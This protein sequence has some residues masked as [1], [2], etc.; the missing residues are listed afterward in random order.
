MQTAASFPKN[1][2]CRNVGL[3]L[4]AFAAGWMLKPAAS[5]HTAGTLPTVKAASP[6]SMDAPPVHSILALGQR[7]TDEAFAFLQ[8]LSA[9]DELAV[10]FGKLWLSRW[11][12]RESAQAAWAAALSLP[13]GAWRDAVMERL[14]PDLE[15]SVP[16]YAWRES[17]RLSTEAAF[18]AREGMVQ[19]QLEGGASPAD[20]ASLLADTPAEEKEAAASIMLAALTRQS[21]ENAAALLQTLTDPA[22]KEAA[23]VG[24]TA[25]WAATAPEAAA[26]WCLNNATEAG[27][28]IS[29]V[30]QTWCLAD[31]PA[32]SAWLAKLPAGPIRDQGAYSLIES[33][34][35]TNPDLA[36]KWTEQLSDPAAR[37]TFQDRLNLADFTAADP[38]S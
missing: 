27:A 18:A 23:A 13:E 16:A 5:P 35:H 10:A 26:D 8:A 19:R 17:F 1:L 24:F 12:P 37:K 25:A 33:L 11:Q 3:M 2:L 32:A 30:L 7:G 36:W 29:A 20:F 6:G 34:A 14:W 21:P 38:H 15:K 4:S 9:D 28:S 31:I 22:L